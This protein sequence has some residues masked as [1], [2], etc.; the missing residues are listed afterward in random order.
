MR[1]R[2][3]GFELGASNLGFQLLQN[4]HLRTG[5]L[6]PIDRPLTCIPSRTDYREALEGCFES[7]M[8]QTYN[9]CR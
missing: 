4:L 5:L 3:I 6:I 1:S 9:F 7:A 2:P 8:S